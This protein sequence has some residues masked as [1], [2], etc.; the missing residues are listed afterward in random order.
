MG[1]I[2]VLV[3]A[4]VVISRRERRR[5]EGP[6]SQP[7]ATQTV[8]DAVDRR[9]ARP[10]RARPTTGGRRPPRRAGAAD[11]RVR[12]RQAAGRRQEADLQ[13]GRHD[14][15]DRHVRHRRRGPLPRLRRPQGRAPRAARCTFSFPATIEGSSSSSSRTT[16][17][18]AESTSR[19]ETPAGASPRALA[20]GA[21]RWRCPASALAHGLVGKQDLPIPRWLFAWAAA[22][23]LV[24]SFVGARRAVAAPAPGARARARACCAC[25]RSLEVAVRRARAWPPSSSPSTRA[26]RARRRRPPTSRRPSST[27]SS[28]S[29]IPFAT[30]LLGD[31]F[32]R[33]QP[34]ARRRRAASAWV[35]GRA[36]RG[37]EAP[38]P[39][40]YPAWLGRW[41]AAL[42]ILAFA[43]VELVYVNKDDP[44][45]LATMALLY[46][47]VQLVGM[48]LYGIERVDAQRRRVRRLLPAV[49]DA[50]AAALARRARC[51][52]ARRWPARRSST[53]APGTVA[54]LCTMIGTVS[55]DGLSQ[56][57]LW[58]G[59]AAIAPAAPAALHQ[60]R[61]QRRGGARDHLHGRPADHGGPR[62][63][64]ST[65]WA[66]S[67]CARSAAA[68]R[69]RA[70]AALRA[71][72]D[73]D[74]AGLRRRALLLAADLPGPGD[75]L[76]HL[77]PARPRLEPVRH[78]DGDDRLQRRRRQRRL[79]RA[80]R[81]AR[82]RPRVPA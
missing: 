1:A 79:V 72:A 36:R 77:R 26:S 50:L 33:L 3:V 16:E 81:R 32:A 43:W 66:C 22:V 64:A 40:A 60:P 12:R 59:R 41:P 58:T 8:V 21:A 7:A 25:P 11:R 54:L 55:F 20:L 31:V 61:L 17:Q 65:A 62:S 45:Q 9:A 75:G 4:Y 56:G 19:R 49:L 48:S 80:G 78:R 39:L 76:P 82:A 23:V 74:R 10:T 42:G 38:A 68:T 2:V 13:Q 57:A 6:R 35:Y 29:A 63:A 47:A 30:L 24:V 52:C 18:I 37:G 14:R 44:S 46:A 53:P 5:Q 73:P 67:G 51:T 34:V 28:G 71:L 15:F 69:H 70:V 27:S